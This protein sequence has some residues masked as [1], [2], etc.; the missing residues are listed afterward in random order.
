MKKYYQENPLNAIL[1]IAFLVR[2]VA[3][4]FSEGYGM[5]DDHFLIVEVAQ[6]WL[7]GFDEYKW[8]PGPTNPNAA[9]TGHVLLYTGI[10]Y[11]IFKIFAFIG[12][13]E[14]NIKMLILRLLHA[15]LSLV[16]V[17]Y[18]YKITEKLSNSATAKTV[19]WM[20]AMLWFIP[21]LSVRN[22]VE[23]VCIPP[24]IYGTWLI[25]N[26]DKKAVLQFLLAGFITGLAFSIRFQ[27]STFIA[28]LGIV[29]WIQYKF[30]NAIFYGMGVILSILFFQV[31]VDMYI[32]GKP[33]AEFMA[34]SVYNVDNAY[35]YIVGNWYNYL[36]LIGGI[37]I[38]P[39]SIFIAYGFAL[40]WRK[41]LVLFLPA[42]LF[43]IFHSAF[44][45]KQERFIMPV[46]PFII[47][48]G[49]ITWNNLQETN[50]Y[51]I[52]HK[53][54]IANSWKFFWILNTIILIVLTPSST[55][56]SRV[57]AMNYL[58]TK[59]DVNSFIFESS[60]SGTVLMPRYYLKKWVNYYNVTKEYPS[61]I[62]IKYL[63]STNTELPNYLIVGEAEKLVSRLAPCIKNFGKV[64]YLATIEPSFLDRFMHWINPFG[65]ENQ[66]YYIYKFDRK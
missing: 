56:I 37:L 30:K 36:L 60:N 64:K 63:K 15:L 9:A 61:D 1:I 54:F 66:T 44:P 35:N 2:L 7:D 26:N 40:S 6:N 22:L 46:I 4:I 45:N 41:H 13:N 12:I 27:T 38:P 14:P 29:V 23:M 21:M 3:V 51:F 25:V 20:C 58:S 52:K 17:K 65:N 55:K 11:Y 32:W 53:N 42:L 34:Y 43:F 31:S 33:L 18:A 62:L 39:V 10:H 8:L 49:L 28:G 16:V 19:A 59:A 5:S 48:A 57:N 50:A 47:M 24:L